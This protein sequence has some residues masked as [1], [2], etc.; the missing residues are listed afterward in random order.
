MVGW[1][2]LREHSRDRFIPL[3]GWGGEGEGRTSY[4]TL[5]SYITHVVQRTTHPVDRHS[6]HQASSQS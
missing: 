4:T 5:M 1:M 2:G 6:P 3:A